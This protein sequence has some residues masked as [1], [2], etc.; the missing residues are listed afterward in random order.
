MLQRSLVNFYRYFLH[1]ERALDH[2]NLVAQMNEFLA[3]R[4]GSIEKQ[5]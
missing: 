2:L 1:S 3:S 5:E 4:S